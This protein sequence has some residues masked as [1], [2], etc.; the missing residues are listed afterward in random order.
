MAVN[1]CG[2]GADRRKKDVAFAKAAWRE[3]VTTAKEERQ[4]THPYGSSVTR[5][6]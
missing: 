1:A 6:W 3:K 2:Q 5:K 4:K